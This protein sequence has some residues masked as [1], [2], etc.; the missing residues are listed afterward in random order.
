[1]KNFLHHLEYEQSGL[2][3]AKLEELIKNRKIMYNH[4]ADKKNI[5]KWSNQ[6]NLEKVELE[7]LPNYIKENKIKFSE[8]ID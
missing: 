7:S 3:A 6:I 5:S 4:R 2:N 1:M 8:W